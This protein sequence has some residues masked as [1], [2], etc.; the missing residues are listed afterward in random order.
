M[1]HLYIHHRTVYRYTSPVKFGLHRLVLRPHEGHRTTVLSHDLTLE[2]EANLTWMKDIFGNHVA[3]AEF[4][5]PASE[6]VVNNE[7]LLDQID[8]DHDSGAAMISRLSEVTFP[9]S[10]LQAE[11][12]MVDAYLQPVY[13]EETQDVLRWVHSL[14]GSEITGTAFD[15][16]T[17]LVSGIYQKI[18]YRRR[19]EP[20]VQSPMMTLKLGTGSCRDLATL[21]IEA[22]RCLGLA[23]RFVSG[24]SDS[25]AAAAG[26]G[27][28]HAWMDIYFPD[29]GWQGFDPTLGRP[30]DKRHIALGVSTHP[31]GVMPVSGTFDSTMGAS[32]GMNVAIT[33]KREPTRGRS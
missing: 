31:R 24:Y 17:N 16:V 23:A 19:E 1:S 9:L 11:K 28:T 22:A 6:L 12:P 32:L 10:Y 33:I 30:T 5:Y 29:S 27:S 3:F 4:P 20:G 21:G 2:P 15:A 13:E 25:P 14:L 26:R 8:G 18:A 7:V